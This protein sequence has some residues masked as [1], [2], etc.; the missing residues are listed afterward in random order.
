MLTSRDVQGKPVSVIIDYLEGR[1]AMGKALGDPFFAVEQTIEALLHPQ[2]LALFNTWARI[3]DPL[4]P[5]VTATQNIRIDKWVEQFDFRAQME[6]EAV[7]G[8]LANQLA[9]LLLRTIH[10]LTKQSLHAMFADAAV[11]Y[12]HQI[13]PVAKGIANDALMGSFRAWNK[14]FGNMKGSPETHRRPCKGASWSLLN[15]Y[16][17]E[18]SS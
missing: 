18:P 2:V 5:M 14:A 3:K 17:T 4:A 12:R 16:P 13:T 15:L 9:T 10:E 7:G 6:A 1:I 8:D 11:K